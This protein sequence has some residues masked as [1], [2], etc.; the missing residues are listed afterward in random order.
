[1]RQLCDEKKLLLLIDSVQWAFRSGRFQSYQRVLEKC[2]GGEKFLPDGISMGEVPRRRR[3]HRRVWVRR[4]CDLLGAGCMHDLRVR[5]LPAPG[6][7]EK[8]WTSS[9]GKTHD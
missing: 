3:A 9:K 5:R 1:L 7:V 4:L 6:G 8:S 2:S